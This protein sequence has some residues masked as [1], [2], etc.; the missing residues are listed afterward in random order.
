MASDDDQSTAEQLDPS[1]LGE[2]PGDPGR[3]ADRDYPPDEPLGV[4]DPALDPAA[5]DVE[6]DDA[7][8][9]AWREQPEPGTRDED[10]S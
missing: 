3:A 10:P 5:G 6:P 4:D 2:Q 1:K 7:A 9:R 8:R